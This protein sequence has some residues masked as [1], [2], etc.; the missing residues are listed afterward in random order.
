LTAAVVSDHQEAAADLG[1]V[2]ITFF[3]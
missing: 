3:D 2:E 1:V